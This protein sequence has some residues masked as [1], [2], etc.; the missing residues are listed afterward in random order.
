MKGLGMKFFSVLTYRFLMIFLLL[1]FGLCFG[2]LQAQEAEGKMMPVNRTF[3]FEGDQSH[4]KRLEKS[5][6]ANNAAEQG[7]EL[8]SVRFNKASTEG[9][10]NAGLSDIAIIRQYFSAA[11]SRQTVQEN[12]NA[13]RLYMEGTG[14]TASAIQS[15]GSGNIMN[16]GIYGNANKGDY[17]QKGSNNYIFDRIGNQK[18]PVSGVTHKIHQVGSNLGTVNQGIQTIPMRIE[19]RGPGMWLHIRGSPLP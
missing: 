10:E 11:S 8:V 18:N 6:E 9:L 12:G 14:N 16:L 15:Q 5:T 19:Q 1:G 17:L 7:F 3:A 4:A 13:I 2:E